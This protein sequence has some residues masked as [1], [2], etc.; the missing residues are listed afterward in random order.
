MTIDVVPEDGP[1]D[2]P[3]GVSDEAPEGEE[4]T[5]G[6][7]TVEDTPEHEESLEDAT[8]EGGHSLDVP[9]ETPGSTEP[10]DDPPGD[11]GD[12]G[13]KEAEYP[14]I[15]PGVAEIDPAGGEP[16]TEDSPV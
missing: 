6:G 4:A 1:A 5:A 9:A 16:R 13:P 12:D 7:S 10:G 15:E 2:E 3:S 11:A 14:P 8:A